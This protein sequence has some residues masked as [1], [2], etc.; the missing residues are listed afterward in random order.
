M[1][2]RLLYPC[3]YLLFLSKLS[4]I[5][6]SH[7]PSCNFHLNSHCTKRFSCK[8]TKMSKN[9][10]LQ[11]KLFT[12]GQALIHDCNESA[13]FCYRTAEVS[14]P[15]IRFPSSLTV[16]SCLFL[17]F[18]SFVSSLILGF[19]SNSFMSVFCNQLHSACSTPRICKAF[20]KH[21]SEELCTTFPNNE[22]LVGRLCIM[23]HIFSSTETKAHLLIAGLFLNLFVWV[24]FV[25]T[26]D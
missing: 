11:N 2:L 3:K 20:L 5:F 21:T 12:A 17:H 25:F 26:V 14:V 23:G 1:K 6:Y 18:T 9:E 4:S 13:S 24:F 19:P 10:Q 22:L 16:P 15:Q 7:N 8:C